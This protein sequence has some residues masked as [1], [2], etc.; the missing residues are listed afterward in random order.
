MARE[1]GRI[2]SVLFVDSG[3]RTGILRITGSAGSGV[4]TEHGL[5]LT[6]QHC[7]TPALQQAAV[8]A[9]QQKC[10][11]LWVMLDAIDAKCRTIGN[12]QL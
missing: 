9:L 1:A 12:P 6:L 8:D 2:P 7:D 3:E 4:I 11:I 10:D 5:H